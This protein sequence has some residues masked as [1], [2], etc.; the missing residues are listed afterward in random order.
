MHR[1]VPIGLSALHVLACGG[2]AISQEAGAVRE[3]AIGVVDSVERSQWLFGEKASALA[4]LAALEAECAVRGWDADD[5]EAIS[6]IV[7]SAAKLFVRLLPND[8]PPPEFA[9]EPDGCI[10]LDWSRSS[11]QLFSLSIGRSNRLAYAWLDGSNKGH[12]VEHFDGHNIPVRIIE[13]IQG[14]VG[15]H[16][17]VRAD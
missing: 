15:R 6:P 2:T 10:S 9:A 1:I 12:G 8:I 7:T 14:I 4:A 3:A 13:G 5:A 11:T 16:A 17:S